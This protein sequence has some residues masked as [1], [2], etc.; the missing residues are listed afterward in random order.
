MTKPPRKKSA[1]AGAKK[2]AP[3]VARTPAK[4]NAIVSGPR[5]QSTAL[6][7]ARDLAA[8]V[9]R[10][11]A[12]IED[13]RARVVRAV[14]SEMVLSYWHIGRELVEFVQ[15]G[16]A[17]AEYG[18]EVIEGLSRQLLT[19]VG[20]GYSARNLWYFRDFFLTFRERTPKIRAEGFRTSLVQN[21]K[22]AD[23]S[24]ILHEAGAELAEGFSSRLS[25]THYRALLAV[26]DPA[27]R[28]FYEIEAEI[29]NWSTP[30]LERQVFTSLHLRLL[31]SRNKAGV[32]ELARKGQTVERPSDLIKSPLIL[33]FLG[34]DDH[35]GYRESDLETAILSKLSQFLLELGKGFAFVARQK[36][37]TFDDD[38]LF[39]DLVFYNVLLKCYL[40][41]DLKL[42]R[43]AHQDVGQMDSYVRMFDAHERKPGDGPTIGLILC[44][45]ENHT[46]ARYSVLSEYKQLFAAKYLTHLPTEEELG[47]QLDRDRRLAEAT[48]E[49]PSTRE[50]TKPGRGGRRRR[51]RKK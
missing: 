3:P 8:L 41:I 19:R 10:V 16:E 37:I 32:M 42:G 15:H 18:K 25:W 44:A 28:A 31:K 35:H 20:K 39:I 14:N 24:K 23:A 48:V 26:S 46:I 13:A 21:S 30:Q 51:G 47:R 29:E 11:V 43:L 27:A 4:A 5:R 36:R 12:I 7:G 34:L 9:E 50:P 49:A 38:Q 33:D 1:K 40:L 17:R 45:E 22:P 6:A 2:V